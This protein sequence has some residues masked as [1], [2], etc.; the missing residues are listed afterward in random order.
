MKNYI[1]Q[2]LKWYS[3]YTIMIL[4][5]WFVGYYMGV[6]IANAGEMNKAN[7]ISI[8]DV[9]QVVNIK[10][11]YSVEVCREVQ[12]QSGSIFSGTNEALKG[13][14][15]SLLGAIIGGV[16]GNKVGNGN[17][18]ATVLGVIIGSNIGN[19]TSDSS[20]K[21]VCSQETRYNEVQKVQY[22][23]TVMVVEYNGYFKTITFNKN[24]R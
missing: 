7:I 17:D 13:N 22:T 2:K 16:I 19:E 21:T 5:A 9:N 11:P 1:L 6:G 10:Q 15:D 4:S 23:H 18:G 14:G 8:E 20:K 12:V 3:V 24:E